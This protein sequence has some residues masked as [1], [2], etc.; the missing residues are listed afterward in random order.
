MPLPEHWEAVLHQSRLHSAKMFC[1]H[2]EQPSTFRIVADDSTKH[3]HYAIIECNYVKCR[4]RVFV[5]TTNV[6]NGPNQNAAQDSLVY[7]P[8]GPVP[9]AHESLPA[10][11]AEDWVDAQKV[12]GVE[13]VKAAAVM[14]RR[15]LYGVLLEKKCKEHPLHEGI[16]ELLSKVRLPQIVEEWLKEIKE[17]GHDAAHPFRA[18]NVPAENVA[19]TMGYTK[20]LLRFV[21]VEPFELKKRLARKATPPPPP[22]KI[23][24]TVA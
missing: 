17:D 14:C 4:E 23:P 18:L 15:I 16:A 24:D 8:S 11:I 21:Y 10:P 20:E 6:F 5:I 1:P 3:A 9:K 12:F 22:N 7:Y 13:A 2:C 19:E